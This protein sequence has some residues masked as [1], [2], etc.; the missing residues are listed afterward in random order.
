M[1]TGVEG[2]LWSGGSALAQA[3]LVILCKC[4][5]HVPLT[6]YGL[7]WLFWAPRCKYL[8]NIHWGELV[9]KKMVCITWNACDFNLWLGPWAA[10]MSVRI[11]NPEQT[12]RNPALSF[13]SSG[14]SP[15]WGLS[16][17]PPPLYY[18][19]AKAACL[20]KIRVQELTFMCKAV[21]SG[22]IYMSW[23]CM[24][25]ANGIYI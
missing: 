15:L 20:W 10:G 16:T 17:L 1:A 14:S 24:C 22:E 13:S 6:W 23:I 21:I 25:A 19:L 18:D 3:L 11:N 8:M 5:L 12:V 4:L 2:G 9:L 7:L